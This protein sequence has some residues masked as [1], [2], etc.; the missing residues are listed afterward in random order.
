M[1][2]SVISCLRYEDAPAAID[3]LCN[4][5]GFQRHAVYADEANPALIHH[6][7]LILGEAMI[8]LSTAT[9]GGIAETYRMKTP[10]QAGL[11]T[12]S[13]YAVVPDADAHHA[14]AAAAGADILSPPRENEG[15]PG[16]SY[17]VRDTEGYCWNFGSYDP[18]EMK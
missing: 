18:W 17:N 1:R 3:F 9:E 6:A 13:L 7:Q 14:L 4:A 5:F 15:Y 8:M 10:R 16:R 12:S 11:C 2:Q